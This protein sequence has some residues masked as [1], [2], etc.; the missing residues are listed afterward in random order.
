MLT[1]LFA[2]AA[3]HELRHRVLPRSSGWRVRI[4]G[5][6]HTVMAVAMSAMTWSW[7]AQVP[8]R[9]QAVFFAAAALWF[10]LSALSRRGARLPAAARS[11]PSAAGMAAMAWMARPMAG[12]GHETPAVHAGH[13]TGD[14]GTHDAGTVILVL[15][16]LACALRSL[17][18]DMPGLRRNTSSPHTPAVKDLY[19][20]FCEGAM[21][22]GTVVMLLLHQ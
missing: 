16:L 19:G 9:A 8:T 5:L 2:A 10:P 21:Q 14:P 15:Y 22:L 12:S 7:G 18:R 4:D 1:V 11:L 17:T 6:L 13:S 3:I 20:H